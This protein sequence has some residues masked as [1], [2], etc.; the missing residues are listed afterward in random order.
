VWTGP[1]PKLG[2]N[3]AS[4]VA[5]FGGELA[6]TPILINCQHHILE[7]NESCL[8]NKE[9]KQVDPHSKVCEPTESLQSSDLANNYTRSH[10]DNKADD[11]A[12]ASFRD[13]RDGLAV[14]ENEDGDREQELNCLQ[15]IDTMP[16]PS[17]VNSEEAVCITL[18]RVSVRV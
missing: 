15:D 2:P 7:G 1:G 13:L 5:K 10:E 8:R 18:H 17:A 9:N 6:A 3:E 12:D 4:A 16:C 14:R 11:E